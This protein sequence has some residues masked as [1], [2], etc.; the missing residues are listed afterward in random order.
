MRVV[1]IAVT[2][3]LL[4]S[5]AIGGILSVVLA[6]IT[7]VGLVPQ[8]YHVILGLFVGAFLAVFPAA[9]SAWLA[10]RRRAQPY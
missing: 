6:L 9:L 1:L 4:S 5:C 8:P 7:G 10:S 2:T 3:F